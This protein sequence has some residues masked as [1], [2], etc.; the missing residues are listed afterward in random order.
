MCDKRIVVVFPRVIICKQASVRLGC[1][2]YWKMVIVL[3][4][5]ML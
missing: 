4:A 5:A 2:S 3:E 1:H